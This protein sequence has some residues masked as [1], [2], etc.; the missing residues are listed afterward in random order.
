MIQLG[1]EVDGD[2]ELPTDANARELTLACQLLTEIVRLKR[3]GAAGRRE[4]QKL[5]SLALTDPLTGLSNRRFWEEEARR[6]VNG[7]RVCCLVLVDLDH[8]KTT[9]DELGHAVGDAVIQAA[10]SALKSS[11][12]PDDLVARLGGDEFGVLIQDLDEGFAMTVVERLRHSVLTASGQAG[13]R[14]TASAGFVLA[15]EPSDL[16]LLFEVADT[17]LRAAKASGRDQTKR[18]Y[19]GDTIG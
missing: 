13:H 3:E 12:R 14:I 9:N 16:D 15:P 18:G 7:S 17:A 4:R 8:L 10:A 2:V 11:L 19:P 6:R 1:D 5:K